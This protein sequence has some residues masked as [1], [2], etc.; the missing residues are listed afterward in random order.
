MDINLFAVIVLIVLFFNM[1]EGYKKGMVKEIISFV[2]LIFLCLFAALAGNG[3]GSYHDGK[4]LNVFVTVF[5]LAVLGILHHLIK[6]AVFPA[7]VISKLPVIHGLD[8]ILGVA[9]GALET[10]L[11]LWTVYVFVAIMNLGE[12]GTYIMNSTTEIPAL[13]W[14]YEHNQLVVWLEMLGATITSQLHVEI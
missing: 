6:V 2:S 4:M 3:I 14:L 10:I 1:C 9:V 5:L 13:A 12:I 7:K 11:I 8:K